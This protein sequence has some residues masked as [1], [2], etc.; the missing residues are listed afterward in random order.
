MWIS[1]TR[2]RV[3]V[4]LPEASDAVSASTDD[5]LSAGFSKPTDG[6]DETTHSSDDICHH[7]LSSAMT[8]STVEEITFGGTR[9]RLRVSGLG[10]LAA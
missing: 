3:V 8:T 4:A 7:E 1:A 2:V 10:W 9:R 5:D 6:G